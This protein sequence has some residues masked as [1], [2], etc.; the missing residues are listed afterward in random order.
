[1]PVL[2]R[3]QLAAVIKAARDNGPLDEALL[4]LLADRG[5]RISEAAAIRVADL[6]LG[7]APR[8]LIHG[9]G[10]KDR[11]VIPGGWTAL[12][13]RRWLRSRPQ[14]S[15]WLFPGRGSHMTAA[16]L[17]RKVVAAGQRAGVP[18]HPHQLRHTWAHHFRAEG[19][20]LDDLVYLAGWT[21]RRWL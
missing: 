15:E 2:S 17:Y 12:A 19:G 9:K 11:I 6:E 8:L 14:G 21:A 16:N 1:M 5:I 20:A 3:Q 18:V 13:L 10:G 7:Q 4:R